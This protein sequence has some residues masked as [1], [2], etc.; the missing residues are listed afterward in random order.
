MSVL[1]ICADG[2]RLVVRT[3]R[4]TNEIQRDVIASQPVA[5]GGLDG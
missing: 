1:D 4:G 5:R 3:V 2:E